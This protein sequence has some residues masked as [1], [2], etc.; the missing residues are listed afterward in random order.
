MGLRGQAHRWLAA[1][2]HAAAALCRRPARRRGH[3]LLLE[4]RLP[5]E[6]RAV[7]RPHRAW[8]R[9]RTALCRRAHRLGGR[10][11]PARR[12]LRRRVVRP[13]VVRP[14]ASGPWPELPWQDWEPTIS[15]LHM[16]LQIVGKVRMALT[17]PVN[18]WWHAPLYVSARGLTTSAIPYGDSDFEIEFDF[19]EHR[20]TIV[21]AQPGAFVMDLGPRSVAD[22]YR[23]FMAGLRERG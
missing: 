16:W 8:L 6:R 18:H 19:V 2:R 23:Q 3:R 7:S 4:C 15:T 11:T 10:R 14:L 5:L 1:F 13:S 21:D 12:R 17:P 20:L 22:F 9:Q